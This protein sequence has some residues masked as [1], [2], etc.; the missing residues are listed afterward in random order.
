MSYGKWDTI[1]VDYVGTL[2]KEEVREIM[3]LRDEGK[4]SKEISDHLG[5]TLL[6]INEVITKNSNKFQI[7]KEEAMKNTEIIKSSD[8]M[9]DIKDTDIVKLTRTLL[10]SMVASTGLT[11]PQEMTS[12]KLQEAK[13]VLGYVNAQIHAI[14][15]K[16]Q[17][18][19][20]IG[21]DEKV[22]AVKDH[23]KDL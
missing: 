23:N 22:K 3:F 11:N 18:F 19:K 1:D 6:I 2:D 17:F 8:S 20:M 15:T 13:V 14:K 21:L 12:S 10:N 16:M 9:E 7:N 5:R 4:T